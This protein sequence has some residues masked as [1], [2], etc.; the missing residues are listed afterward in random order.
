MNALS[1][2]QIQTYVCIYRAFQTQILSAPS[3]FNILMSLYFVFH[4]SHFKSLN[5]SEGKKEKKKLLFCYH[6]EKKNSSYE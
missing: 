2:V 4:V 5:E 3:V 1:T 6:D